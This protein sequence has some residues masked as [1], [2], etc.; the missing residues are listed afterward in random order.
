GALA[1]PYAAV[2]GDGRIPL[3]LAMLMTTPPPGCACI[4]AF[5][6]CANTSGAT[7]FSV[8]IEVEN[9][10]D[11]VAE[12]AGGE[13]PALLTSTSI[14]PNRFVVNPTT[15]SISSGSRTS[16]TTNTASRSAQRGTPPGPWPPPP[17]P[18]PPPPPNPPPLPRPIP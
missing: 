14:R 7:R 12:S 11:T 8:M 5:A 4:T 6:F 13:P 2:P 16:A 10:G 1:A 17:P 3:T 15:L 9:F 18:F